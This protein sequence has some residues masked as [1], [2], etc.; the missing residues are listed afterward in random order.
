[1]SGYPKC[2]RIFRQFSDSPKFKGGGIAPPLTCHD[3]TVY[4]YDHC[5]V[6]LLLTFDLSRICRTVCCTAARRTT[7]PQEQ[8]EASG[9]W[10]LRRAYDATEMNGGELNR[11]EM[12]V[13]LRCMQGERTGTCRSVHLT[14]Y[15]VQFSSFVVH[16]PSS[17]PVL[18]LSRHVHRSCHVVV[19]RRW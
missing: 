19:R 6:D 5:R 9:G 4:K 14:K 18:L 16:A 3:A 7:K 13:Q 17:V 2:V 11:T 1:M 10:A 12:P 15:T 8:I